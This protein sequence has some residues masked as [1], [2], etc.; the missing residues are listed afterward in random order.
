[1]CAPELSKCHLSTFAATINILVLTGKLLHV[2]IQVKI[3]ASGQ[4]QIVINIPETSR[5][6]DAS[7]KKAKKVMRPFALGSQSSFLSK[8]N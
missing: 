2:S 1:M 4:I 3:F 8:L 5:K 7:I 6:S